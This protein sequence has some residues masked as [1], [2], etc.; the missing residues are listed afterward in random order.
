MKLVPRTLKRP[1]HKYAIDAAYL[2]DERAL[3]WT[4]LGDWQN[5]D[6]YKTACQQL[7]DHLAQAVQLNA[8][9][10]VLDLGCGQG[11]SLHH[12]LTHY[13]IQHLTGIELQADQVQ[14][15]RQQLGQQVRVEQGSFLN[16]NAFNFRQSFDVALC[17]DA[18]YHSNLQHFLNAVR[19]VLKSNGRVGFHY[20]MLS[21]QWQQLSA[22]RKQKYRYLLKLADVELSH[23][24]DCTTMTQHIKQQGFHQVQITD[25]SASV[26]GGFAD[27]IRSSTVQNNKDLAQIKIW[28]TAKLCGYLY[29]KG[30]IRYVQIRASK[31]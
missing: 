1:A 18:A 27:Y 9:D 4:N 13:Q 30:V 23:L 28:A 11:A 14:R 21:D 15:I 7:A 31:D 19:A 24:N 8:S 12:W 10:H 16:L 17:I 5:T 25:I 26:L 2:G 6:D 29:Q 3:A 20:L 22:L